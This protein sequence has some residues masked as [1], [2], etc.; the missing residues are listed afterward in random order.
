[1]SEFWH[2]ATIW[3]LRS[4]VAGGVTLLLAWL[5]VRRVQDPAR[6]HRVIGWSV[7]AAMLACV[8]AVLPAWLLVP[9][10]GWT[11]EGQPEHPCGDCADVVPVEVAR[12]EEPPVAEELVWVPVDFDVNVEVEEPAVAAAAPAPLPEPDPHAL[13]ISAVPMTGEV[14][15]A[16][17]PPRDMVAEVAPVILIPYWLCVGFVLLRQL[18]GYV[19]L[20]RLRRSAVPAAEDVQQIVAELATDMRPPCVLVSDR[21]AT[22]VCFGVFTPTILLPRALART[23]TLDQLRWVLAHELD[24]LRRGDPRT[25]VWVGLAR[26]VYFALPWFWAVRRELSLAQEYLADAAAAG[27]QEADYA[28]FLVELSSRPGVPRSVRAV[29]SL[30]GVRAGQSDLYRRVTMLLQPKSE[31][32]SRW[33]RAWSALAIGS[34]VSATVVLS[35][36]RLTAD[37]PKKVDK[38]PVEGR[39]EVRLADGEKLKEKAKKDGDKKADAV[40]H[41]IELVVVGNDKA[42]AE[43]EKAIEE[44]AKKGDVKAVKELVAK[45][46]AATVAHGIPG[47]AK[48]MPPAVPLPPV[49]PEAVVK[50]RLALDEETQH[51]QKAL[52][53]LTKAAEDVKDQPEAKAALEKSAAEYRKKLA[54]AKDK[55]GKAGDAAKHAEVA[56]ADALRKWTMPNTTALDQVKAN[57]AEMMKAYEKQLSGLKDDPKAA[58]AVKEAM[59]AYKANMDKLMKQLSGL[60][61][62]QFQ[63]Q[64]F[65]PMQA[66]P[67]KGFEM[68]ELH[69]LH[70]KV[71]TAKPAQG[72]RFGVTIEAVPAILVEQLDLPKGQGAILL[73]VSDGSPAAKAGLKANDVLLEVKGKAVTAEGLPTVIAGMKGDETFDVVI[74]RKGKKETVKGIALPAVK[75]E[76]KKDKGK[77]ASKSIKVEDDKFEIRAEEDGLKFELK[78][79]VGDTGS[80]EIE[81]EKDKKKFFDGKGVKSVPAEYREKVEELLKGVGK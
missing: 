43:I 71:Y 29:P 1:M 75:T 8:L 25:G 24:H 57:M 32:K 26:A 51:L 78:G 4:L 74:V 28:A 70:G 17:V 18:V 67:L 65:Q 49:P 77:A 31:S 66:L 45:L 69:D 59:A 81:I 13:T 22:P 21:L 10:P 62:G 53:K 3:T 68:K 39:V 15:A 47:I 41:R 33:G 5:A 16:P 72:G 46:K 55:A 36:I 11:A 60:Q 56:R 48:V 54:E 44:A 20:A 40:E 80:V 76:T 12:V 58:E 61:G 35:G 2:A 19:G 9:V 14:A 6:R 38:K 64:Q 50:M 52:E 42:T 79:T 73:S 7:R 34:A 63:W 30:A 23:A 37:E 27:A